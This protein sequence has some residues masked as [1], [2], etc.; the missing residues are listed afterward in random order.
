MKIR[1]TAAALAT[2]LVAG[3]AAAT[4]AQAQ[5]PGTDRKLGH[6]SLAKVLAADGNKFD[7]NW[8]DFDI[9]DKAVHLVL[10][11]KPDS[12]V[13]VLAHGRKR[14]TAFLPTD[15]AFRKLVKQA[16]GTAP[17]TEKEAYQQLKAIAAQLSPSDPVTL[18]ENILLYH[19][20]PGATITY[21]Q[22]KKADGAKLQT[23]FP[24][25]LTIK[26]DVQGRK[27]FLKDKDPDDTNPHVI[28]PRNINKGNRQIAHAIN[29]ILRP[30]NLSAP[31]A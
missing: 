10:K 12:P 28:R 15:K 22:A 23:A 11:N 26:V 27:V 8:G 2:V 13:G 7:Q 30:A 1:Y 21:R 20:V 29:L 5:A 6:K 9:V 31:S 14:V 19:V 4:P 3:T 18:V 17:A 24:G 16:T 25:G